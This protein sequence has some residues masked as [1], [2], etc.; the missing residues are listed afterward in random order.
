MLKKKIVKNFN[1]KKAYTL[2]E[3]SIAILVISLLMAGVFSM[4]TGSISGSKSVLATQRM[5]EIY[6]SIGTYLMI[7]KRLPC[8]ASIELSKVNDVS[9]GQEVRAVANGIATGCGG[10]NTGV[11]KSSSN[12]NLSF[13]AVP[14]KSLNLSSEY[15]EDGYDNKIGYVV[16]RRFTLDFVEPGISTGD[17]FGTIDVDNETFPAV[18]TIKEK[19][20]TLD[21]VLGNKFIFVLIS[22]GANGNGAF[23]ANDGGQ[24]VTTSSAETSGEYE[25]QVISKDFDGVFINNSYGNDIFDDVLFY[26]SRP[27]FIVDFSANNFSYCPA[28][29]VGNS[30]FVATN[31]YYNQYLYSNETCPGDATKI[32]IKRCTNISGEWKD[33][34]ATCPIV[35]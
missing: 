34:M 19:N 28:F 12:T 35:L 21:S 25:N 16:D 1:D 11:Y 6:K 31:L 20:T 24:N 27:D 29:E 2:I 4:A 14:I 5:N 32:K 17:S 30:G 18:I 7:N 15:S 23:R 33:A 13:G 8:P 10:V 26:K 9:Y 22:Y 3:L